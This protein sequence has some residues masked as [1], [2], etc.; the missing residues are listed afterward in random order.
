MNWQ[1]WTKYICPVTNVERT[2]FRNT[3]TDIHGLIKELRKP[4]WRKHDDGLGRKPNLWEEF[5]EHHDLMKYMEDNK[6]HVRRHF[7]RGH[8]HVIEDFSENGDFVVRLEHQ[9]R[10]YQTH[11]YTLFGIVVEVHVEDIKDCL[12]SRAERTKLIEMLNQERPGEPHVLTF[13]HIIVSEDTHHDPAAVMHFNS[14]VL[15]PWLRTNVEGFAVPEG[16]AGSAVIHYTTDGAPTQFANKDIYLWISRCYEKHKIKVDWVIGCAAHNKD[17]ADGECG[18]AKN[19]VTTVNLEYDHTGQT[20]DR[21]TQ[22]QTV[23][24]VKKHLEEKFVLQKTIYDKKGRGIYTRVIHHVKLGDIN[25]RIPTAQPLRGSKTLHQVVGYGPKGHVMVRPRPCHVCDGC[26]KL[27]VTDIINKCAFKERCGVAYTTSMTGTSGAVVLTGEEAASTAKQIVEATKVGD[28][29]AVEVHDHPLPWLLGEVV[30]PSQVDGAKDITG[31][32]F[33]WGTDTNEDKD[34]GITV[35]ENDHVLAVRLWMPLDNGG[36]SSLFKFR[37]GTDD[38]NPVTVFAMHVGHVRYR[39]PKD[40]ANDTKTGLFKVRRGRAP[41][42]CRKLHGVVKNKD[43]AGVAAAECD[44]CD[45]T[46]CLYTCNK[47]DTNGDATCDYDLCADCHEMKGQIRTLKSETKTAIFNCI[48]NVGGPSDP[49]FGLTSEVN[50]GVWHGLYT[51]KHAA[52]TVQ[53]IAMALQVSQLELTNHNQFQQR[54]SGGRRIDRELTAGSRFTV[55]T[56]LWCPGGGSYKDCTN[57][58]CGQDE[59]KYDG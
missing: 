53:S 51:V 55:G 31:V 6:A 25:R 56:T 54:T 40:D 24:A 34:T 49:Y 29:V 32:S 23:P 43:A 16:Q 15:F 17:V 13:M 18:H 35:K 28:F 41:V 33:K 30:A 48:P 42:E 21:D 39:I 26:K 10:Y 46:S 1:Q 20:D 14:E 57:G 50:G 5:L 38:D 47:V 9:S 45:K 3:R 36:G 7:P 8:V 27:N 59:N 12:I 52:E 4:S 19:S 44:I 2:D 37:D 58:C 22:I 11:S